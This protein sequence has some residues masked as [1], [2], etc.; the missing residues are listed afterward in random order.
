LLDEVQPEVAAYGVHPIH[1][2]L[3][4]GTRWQ[5]NFKLPPGLTSG[6]HGVR[7]R[8][9]GRHPGDSYRIAVDLPVDP[10]GPLRITGIADGTKWTRNQLDMCNGGALSLW[11]EGLPENATTCGC[12]WMAV[13][14]RW[15]R[16]NLPR[17]DPAK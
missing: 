5:I 12:G 4:E 6:W 7:V 10:A 2:G 8:V 14:C 17:R 11:V 13:G 9:R 3:S 1:V 15:N 16:W